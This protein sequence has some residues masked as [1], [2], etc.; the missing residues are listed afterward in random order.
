MKKISI[1]IT[2]LIIIACKNSSNTGGNDNKMLIEQKDSLI[3]GTFSKIPA[4]ID[5]CSCYFFLSEKDKKNEQYVCVNDFGNLAFISLNGKLEK[6]EM[7]FSDNTKKEGI[8]SYSNNY[9]SQCFH[10]PYCV[11]C[12]HEP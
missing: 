4:E 10:K 11:L 5:G 7:T 1:L 3:V 2:I 12:F 6:F 9:P 8:Y